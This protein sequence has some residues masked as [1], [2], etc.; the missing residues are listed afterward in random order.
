MTSKCMQRDLRICSG[1][2]LPGEAGHY[3]FL[4]DLTYGITGRLPVTILDIYG[5]LNRVRD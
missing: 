2:S 1:K 3:V 4:P 5:A